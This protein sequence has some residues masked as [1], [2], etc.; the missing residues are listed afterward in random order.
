MSEKQKV[1]VTGFNRFGY[2]QRSNRSSELVLPS[3]KDEY[4][5]LVETLVLPT[6]F[7]IAAEQLITAIDEIH[8]AAVIMFGVSAGSKVRLER[9]AKNRRFNILIPD[10]QGLRTAGR[11]NPE[12]IATY[13]STLPLDDIYDKLNSANVP[14]KL[15]HDAGAFVCNEVMFKALEHTDKASTGSLLPTGFLH[16]GNGLSDQL[17]KEAGLMVV[18]QLLRQ[19]ESV[20]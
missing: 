17:V 15:S 10:N 6:A 1:L 11:L 14:T 4:Q 19:G 2:L 12:G 13:T 16:F 8:P 7:N 5:D 3:I 20:K 9:Y 18:G